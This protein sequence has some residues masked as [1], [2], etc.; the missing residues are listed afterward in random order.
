[1][2]NFEQYNESIRDKM[3]PKSKEDVLKVIG[4]LPDMGYKK[5]EE[6]N[7]GN[8]FGIGS[9]NT[10]YDKLVELFGEP[11]EPKWSWKINYQWLLEDK[12]GN[13]ISIYDWKAL[14]N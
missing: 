7:F 14:E 8:S 11:D 12:D 1:M 3:K 2:F 10:T 9:V 6:K 4:E 13:Y 5:T